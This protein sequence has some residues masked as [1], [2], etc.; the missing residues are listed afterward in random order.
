MSF[1]RQSDGS[2][3]RQKFN[4]EDVTDG[5]PRVVK[6]RMAKSKKSKVSVPDEELEVDREQTQFTNIPGFQE[7]CADKDLL[8]NVL[9][10]LSSE[11]LVLLG[12]SKL[13]ESLVAEQLKKN[14]EWETWKRDRGID[15]W[16]P[17]ASSSKSPQLKLT[18]APK[19][20]KS[21]IHKGKSSV[22]KSSGDVISNKT[23]C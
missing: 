3:E 7:K 5:K 2:Y 6:F 23:M 9:A 22:K 8:L 18:P 11:T 20:R 21:I 10:D 19:K 14:E 4:P 16:E 1:V 13:D 12:E 15:E 17:H